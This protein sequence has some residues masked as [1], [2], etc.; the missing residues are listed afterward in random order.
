MITKA[1]FTDS[2][3]NGLR[4]LFK[5]DKQNKITEETRNDSFVHISETLGERQRIVFENLHKSFKDGATA[6]EL[7]IFLHKKNLVPTPERNSVHPRLNE[8]RAKGLVEVIDKKT[9]QYTD[10]K[11]AIY[12]TKL[13]NNL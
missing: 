1:P 7:A 6:K 13:H 8:L 9:C 10:R 2:L 3:F 11:V 12:R 5:R 4:F